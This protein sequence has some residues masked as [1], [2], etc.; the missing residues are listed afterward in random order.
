M[1]FSRAQDKEGWKSTVTSEEICSGLRVDKNIVYN[2]LCEKTLTKLHTYIKMGQKCVKQ[3]EMND[4]TKCM[5][6]LGKDHVK[7]LENGLNVMNLM[8]H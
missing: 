6:E 2:C 8:H 7:Y 4:D 1:F 5:Y 3:K